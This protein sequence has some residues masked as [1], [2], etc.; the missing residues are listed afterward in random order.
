MNQQ[1]Y[2][3]PWRFNVKG[4]LFCAIAFAP[5]FA[6]RPASPATMRDTLNDNKGKT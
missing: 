1:A 4:F 3:S 5:C 2:Q 6:S